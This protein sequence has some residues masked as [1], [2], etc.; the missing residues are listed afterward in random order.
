LVTD[1]SLSEI[2]RDPASLASGIVPAFKS[3][4]KRISALLSRAQ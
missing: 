3:Y 1:K 2:F 4:A